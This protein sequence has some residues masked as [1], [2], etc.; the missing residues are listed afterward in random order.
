M[1]SYVFVVREGDLDVLG[2]DVGVLEVFGALGDAVIEV[3][4]A[5]RLLL[6][7]R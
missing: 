4:G 3:L 6:R 5:V 2:G 7:G 1:I